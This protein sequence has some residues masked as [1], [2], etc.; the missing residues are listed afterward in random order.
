MPSHPISLRGFVDSF[1]WLGCAGNYWS[2][3]ISHVIPRHLQ[4]CAKKTNLDSSVQHFEKI[5]A[6]AHF[7]HHRI[8]PIKD[9][10]S[11]ENAIEI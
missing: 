9:V 1:G 8:E 7:A 4:A 6:E 3:A 2:I 11:V 5:V 10:S